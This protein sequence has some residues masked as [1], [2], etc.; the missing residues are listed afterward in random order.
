MT[1]HSN[2]NRILN[3]RDCR[4]KCNRYIMK[5]IIDSVK[6]FFALLISN[7]PPPRD[8]DRLEMHSNSKKT[9]S[10][11]IIALMAHRYSPH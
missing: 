7:V 4:C 2:I 6:L 3:T 1:H 5:K 10:D 11:A 8:H 9:Q